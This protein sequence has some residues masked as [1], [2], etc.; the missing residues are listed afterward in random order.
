MAL[1]NTYIHTFVHSFHSSCEGGQSR[2]ANYIY[3]LVVSGAGH[4]GGRGRVR[5]VH[6]GYNRI[7][8]ERGGDAGAVGPTMRLFSTHKA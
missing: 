4:M 2:P 3:I 8:G 5:P 7:I 1:S 6:A